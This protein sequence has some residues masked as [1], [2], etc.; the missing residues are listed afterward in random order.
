MSPRREKVP[1]RS[2]SITRA[3]RFLQRSRFSSFGSRNLDIEHLPF[4]LEAEHVIREGDDGV[5][6]V[7]LNETVA[8]LGCGTLKVVTHAPPHTPM[9]CATTGTAAAL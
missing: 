2:L 4:S 6:V 3:M 9:P 1:V 5:V 8:E 7:S